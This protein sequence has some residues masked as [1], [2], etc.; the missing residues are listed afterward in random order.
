MNPEPWKGVGKLLGTSG[1]QCGMRTGPILWDAKGWAHELGSVLWVPQLNRASRNGS[2][3]CFGGSHEMEHPSSTAGLQQ[4]SGTSAELVIFQVMRWVPCKR[5]QPRVFDREKKGSAANLRAH[6]LEFG[7]PKNWWPPGANGLRVG[8]IVP[9]DM[10]VCPAART[11]WG[12]FP[13][14][15]AFGRAGCPSSPMPLPS[16]VPRP[17]RNGV[18]K[19]CRACQVLW[20]A[21]VCWGCRECPARQQEFSTRQSTS[22]PAGY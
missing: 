5:D 3:S 10:Q 22:R 6:C 2:V 9:L 11:G 13:R 17:L 18:D 16:C 15:L 8:D 21:A 20:A 12:T 7:T 1:H 14:V 19:H 4:T